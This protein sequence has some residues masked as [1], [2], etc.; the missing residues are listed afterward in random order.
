MLLVTITACKRIEEIKDKREIF[1]GNI[2]PLLIGVLRSDG[3][4]LATSCK[5]DRKSLPRCSLYSTSRVSKACSALLAAFALDLFFG[6]KQ[7]EK[8]TPL[9]TFDVATCGGCFFWFICELQT[10][11]TFFA[12]SHIAYGVVIYAVHWE[13]L[14][15][16]YFAR[17]RVCEHFLNHVLAFWRN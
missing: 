15:G 9:T 11:W 2:L 14:L 10:D 8:E 3:P 4:N 1:E 16:F 17:C 7:S 5:Q 12:A 6:L 13:S